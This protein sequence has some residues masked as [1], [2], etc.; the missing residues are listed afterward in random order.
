M[1]IKRDCLCTPVGKNRPLHIYLPDEYFESGER[2]P[3]MYFFDGH[4]LFN[5]EDATYGK[6]WGLKHFLDNWPKRMIIVGFECGHE[7]RERLNEYSPYSWNSN[8]IGKVDGIGDTILDWMVYEVKPMIDA[9]F[10]TWAHREATGIGGS[11]MGG[12]M[13]F[14]GTLKYNDI[15][16]KAACLSTTIIPCWRK[17]SADIKAAGLEADTRIWLSYGEAEAFDRSSAV[18]EI[19]NTKTAQ[20]TDK[21]IK[22]LDEKG[23]MSHSYMQPGGRHCEAD[24]EK[25]IPA[26]M[27][28]LWF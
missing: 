4:N 19:F 20:Y 5:D 24:W 8:Y 17:L 10:R 27:E 16:S 14:Y 25:Q 6:S 21:I 15:F 23:V 3:V 12:L 2:Y 1:I 11:S 18:S 28:Y 26:F 13:S 7:G 9:E 22:M